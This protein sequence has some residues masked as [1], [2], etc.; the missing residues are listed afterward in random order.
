VDLVPAP[1][2]SHPPRSQ[3]AIWRQICSN[4]PQERL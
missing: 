2:C 3:R 4:K 1:T